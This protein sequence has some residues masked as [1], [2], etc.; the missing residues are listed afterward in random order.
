[1]SV[2]FTIPWA[3]G[4]ESIPSGGGYIPSYPG[5]YPGM[6][7][8]RL[9]LTRQGTVHPSLVHVS[10]RRRGCLCVS[11]VGPLCG[12]P[13][14]WWVGPQWGPAPLERV[15]GPAGPVWVPCVCPLCGSPLSGSPVPVC[16]PCVSPRVSPILCW[17]LPSVWVPCFGPLCGSALWIPSVWVPCEG[18]LC[19][20]LGPSRCVVW[21][22]LA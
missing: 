18:P 14:R 12:P 6:E 15:L 19:G 16:V 3:Q 22:L 20:I 5:T 1:M 2:H 17:A 10:K 21:H 9:A 8:P 11:C 4:M 13:L 7:H